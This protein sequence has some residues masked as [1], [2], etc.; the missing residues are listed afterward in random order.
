[1]ACAVF[2][3]TDWCM[4]LSRGLTFRYG[5]VSAS[6]KQFRRSGMP[7]S[8]INDVSIKLTGFSFSLNLVTGDIRTV[9]LVELSGATSLTYPS[10]VPK[11]T[12]HH[13]TR[14]SGT[15]VPPAPKRSRA[16]LSNCPVRAVTM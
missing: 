7:A 2:E 15:M 8:C 5:E 11:L 14:V 4:W 6:E 16:R 10:V 1:M 12:D 13:R 9:C 3:P